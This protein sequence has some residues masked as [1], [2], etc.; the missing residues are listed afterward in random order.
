MEFSIIVS[1]MEHVEKFRHFRCER[2][3]LLC[4][5]VEEWWTLLLFLEIGRIVGE[6]S[7]VFFI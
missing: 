4:A 1:A 6:G 3:F 5:L 7:C 2:M